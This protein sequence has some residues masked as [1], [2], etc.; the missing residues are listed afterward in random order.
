MM[1]HHPKCEWVRAKRELCNCE[2]IAAVQPAEDPFARIRQLEKDLDDWKGRHGKLI[3][4]LSAKVGTT[5]AFALAQAAK[6]EAER[7]AALTE[8]ARLR[9]DDVTELL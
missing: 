1:H 5:A 6:L 4:Q 7:D 9:G 2:R 8:L 3:N